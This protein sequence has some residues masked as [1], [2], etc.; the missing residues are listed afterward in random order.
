MNRVSGASEWSQSTIERCLRTKN[1]PLNGAND[2]RQHAKSICISWKLPIQSHETSVFAAQRIQRI[3]NEHLLSLMKLNFG[4]VHFTFKFDDFF[5]LS[6]VL[7]RFVTSSMS[8]QSHQQK[9]KQRK[10]YFTQNKL[11]SLKKMVGN[12]RWNILENSSRTDGRY[13]FEGNTD[14]MHSIATNFHSESNF[15]CV[16]R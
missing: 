2:G 10:T 5:F 14:Q 13:S 8:F 11:S 3:W 9:K 6:F 12:G 16:V 15:L 1:F 7:L 4:I